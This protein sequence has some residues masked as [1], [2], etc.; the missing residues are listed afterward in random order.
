MYIT[1]FSGR[2]TLFQKCGFVGINHFE[3]AM[4]KKSSG[5]IFKD[6]FSK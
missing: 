5:E 4:Q 6:N 2:G 3:N 1:A